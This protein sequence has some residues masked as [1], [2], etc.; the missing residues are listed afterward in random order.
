LLLFDKDYDG[1]FNLF[2]NGKKD[3]SNDKH[4][5]S[6]LNT[7]IEVKG[8]DSV[9]A[10]NEQQRFEIYKKDVLKLSSWSKLLEEVEVKKE[11]VTCF[12]AIDRAKLPLSEELIKQLLTLNKNKVIYIC[13]KG[14]Y[15]S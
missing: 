11:F 2:K 15:I 5:V 6:H 3:I 14:I 8:S 12:I 9:N 1:I 4:K 13:D 7:L 10:K